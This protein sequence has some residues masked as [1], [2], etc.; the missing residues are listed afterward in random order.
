MATEGKRRVR[1]LLGPWDR[2]LPNEYIE[3]LIIIL[4]ASTGGIAGAWLGGG[5][6]AAVFA[7]VLLPP[8]YVLTR[9]HAPKH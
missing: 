7:T 3:N 2:G 8:F 5:L 1:S 9:L 6:G 4:V